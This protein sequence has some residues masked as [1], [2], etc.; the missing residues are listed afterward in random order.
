M[1]NARMLWVTVVFCVVR[2]TSRAHLTGLSLRRREHANATPGI[3][4][5]IITHAGRMLPGMIPCVAGSQP[6]SSAN[7]MVKM[8]ARCY[9]HMLM[10]PSACS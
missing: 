9:M 4:G 6:C 1:S 7:C 8:H 10:Q 5:I 2:W 3:Y